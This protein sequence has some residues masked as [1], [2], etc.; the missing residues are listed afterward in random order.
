M[1]KLEDFKKLKQNDRIEFML[2]INH[3]EKK[4]SSMYFDW[5]F[6]V[7]FLLAIS[8]FTILLSL[9]FYITEDYDIFIRISS[10]LKPLTTVIFIA[11]FYGVLW[12]L[13]WELCIFKKERKE[14]EE[15]FFKTET[16]PRR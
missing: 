14:L 10:L 12:N 3:L 2:R 5:F 11:I 1:V 15:E 4:Q 8:G 7:L 16:K 9:Q 6:I 13:F